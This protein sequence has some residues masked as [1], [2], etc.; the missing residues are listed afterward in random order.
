LLL[1][2]NYSFSTGAPDMNGAMVTGSAGNDNPLG[3]IVRFPFDVFTGGGGAPGFPGG[4]GGGGG[5]MNEISTALNG[6]GGTGGGGGGLGQ[7][8]SALGGRGGLGGGGGGGRHGGD[9]GNGLV[10]V[11]F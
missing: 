10:I 7:F 5:G 6:H 11:E 4:N 2:D 1:P 9:G 8:T 3:L